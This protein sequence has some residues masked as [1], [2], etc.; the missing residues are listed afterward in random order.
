M[1][2][3]PR[4]IVDSWTLPQRIIISNN[5]TS[6]FKP[7]V[8]KDIEEQLGVVLLSSYLEAGSFCRIKGSLEYINDKEKKNIH[9]IGT[10]FGLVI[11]FN[12]CVSY[13]I[14]EIVLSFFFSFCRLCVQ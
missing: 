13:C 7:L 14:S 11:S 9:L 1:K 5:W 6:N 10:V 8:K 12:G 2:R 4:R 3:I